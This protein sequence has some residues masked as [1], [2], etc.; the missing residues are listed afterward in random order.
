V[1]KDQRY[2][3]LLILAALV[4][5]LLLLFARYP[6]RGAVPATDGPLSDMLLQMLPQRAFADS[7]TENGGRPLWNPFVGLGNDE[8]TTLWFH[9]LYPTTPLSRIFGLASGVALELLLHL[10]LA[11]FGTYCF[12]KALGRSF[13][14]S[15]FGAIAFAGS[16]MFSAYMFAPPMLIAAAWLPWV[17]ATIDRIIKQPSLAW[18]AALGL[19]VGLHAL[20]G[21]MQYTVYFAVLGA[22]YFIF[23][24]AQVESDRFSR[25]EMLLPAGLI[26][27]FLGAGKLLPWLIKAGSMRGGYEDY[28]FFANGLFTFRALFTSVAAHLL[29]LA[30]EVTQL[31][32]RSYL[33][34]IP[35]LLAI[36]GIIALRKQAHVQF[37]GAVAIISALLVFNS[38]LTQAA[39][40][41]VPLFSSLTPPRL[42]LLGVF[43]VAVLASEGFDRFLTGKRVWLRSLVVL[44]ALG[45]AFV[46]IWIAN[47]AIKP[48][49]VYRDTP[50]IQQLRN[51]PG[52]VLRVGNPYS[53]LVNDRVYESQ[54]LLVEQVADLNTFFLM[55]DK[56]LSEAVLEQ[57]GPPA[58]GTP[59]Y[60]LRTRI[61]PVA[62]FESADPEFLDRLQVRYLL[63]QSEIPSLLLRAS[64][65]PLRLYERKVFDSPFHLTNDSAKV[66]SSAW[67]SDFNSITAMVQSEEPFTM[68]LVQ[69]YR[70]NWIVKVDG[71]YGGIR[72]SLDG[73]LPTVNVPAGQHE[74]KFEFYARYVRTADRLTVLG[75]ILA[76]SLLAVGILRAGR[77]S[78]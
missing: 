44:L 62:D 3:R 11:F 56:K 17:M 48:A 51:E 42:W 40:D 30:G 68:E 2:A 32:L 76:F 46:F 54:A 13:H 73:L 15:I 65:G 33:G 47:P 10:L 18:S 25:V 43:A 59:A 26:A 58:D 34:A 77:A 6:L 70:K 24:L 57:L 69:S 72:A 16:G 12:L 50:I 20:A 45:D 36:A 28:E 41:L 49:N 38:P 75:Y 37:F 21:M 9:P 66:L 67:S 55:P 71:K 4:V 31:D 19:F 39:F 27:T 60:F 63:T 61:L 53:F 5:C 1:S 7:V 52:R 22:A 35:I 23:R 78:R 64:D 74:L 29:R 8:S 14:A